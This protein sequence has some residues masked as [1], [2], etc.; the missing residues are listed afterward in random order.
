LAGVKR[1]N[2]IPLNRVYKQKSFSTTEAFLFI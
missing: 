2:K 1:T